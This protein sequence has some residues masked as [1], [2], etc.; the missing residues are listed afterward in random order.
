MLLKAP[1]SDAAE[2]AFAE[3]RAKLPFWN[4][5]AD[6]FRAAALEACRSGVT[7]PGITEDIESV[8]GQIRVALHRCDALID[9]ALPGDHQLTPLIKAAADFEALLESLHASR[10]RIEDFGGSAPRA[11]G[12]VTIAHRAPS[13]PPPR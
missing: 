6:R 8:L 2:L 9:A 13:P 3:W 11:K 7:P 12:P 10:E 1:D 4:I 5:E